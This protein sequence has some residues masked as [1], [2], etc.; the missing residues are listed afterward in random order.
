MKCYNGEESLIRSFPCAAPSSCHASFSG[1]EPPISPFA[2]PKSGCVAPDPPTREPA[3]PQH[4][5]RKE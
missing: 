3:L 5:P 4:M 2:D 1:F